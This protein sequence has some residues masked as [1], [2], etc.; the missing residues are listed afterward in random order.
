MYILEYNGMM[1]MTEEEE[2]ES[3]EGRTTFNRLRG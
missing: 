1:D 3:Q 2:E